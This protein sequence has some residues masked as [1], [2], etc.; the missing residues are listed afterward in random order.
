M[1]RP[2]AQLA[3]EGPNWNNGSSRAISTPKFYGQMNAEFARRAALRELQNYRAGARSG[4]RNAYGTRRNQRASAL[5][6]YFTG[7]SVNN[8]AKG[9]QNRNV[10][11]TKAYLESN[12]AR[13]NAARG[14]NT[15][16][17]NLTKS[18]FALTQKRVNSWTTTEQNLYKAHRVRYQNA[19]NHLVRGGKA[20]G[21]LGYNNKNSKVRGLARLREIGR[22]VSA[23]ARNTAGRVGLGF[24]AGGSRARSTLNYGASG[25]ARGVGMGIR[26]F[27]RGLG[28]AQRITAVANYPRAALAAR[29]GQSKNNLERIRQEILKP[30][31][32]NAGNR[33]TW[34]PMAAVAAQAQRARAAVGGLRRRNALREPLLA[35]N[36]NN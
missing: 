27:G 15:A 26:G 17:K 2:Y 1:A 6:G 30:P 9:F 14:R 3:P 24:R 23:R 13:H 29:R 20:P 34:N 7:K 25:L 5:E 31:P 19:V 21:N 4:M 11:R 28:G 32:R 12:T 10:A 22:G 36:N 18:I 16:R 33:R 35:P 8:F